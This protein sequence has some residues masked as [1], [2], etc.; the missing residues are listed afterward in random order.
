M[1][2]FIMVSYVNVMINFMFA[3]LFNLQL[4]EKLEN[5]GQKWLDY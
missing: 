3:K 2:T 1:V 5:I 4:K